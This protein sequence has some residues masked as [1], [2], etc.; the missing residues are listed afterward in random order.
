MRA[1]LP[2]RFQVAHRACEGRTE[3]VSM[4]GM[5]LLADAAPENGHALTVSVTMPNGNEAQVEAR[6]TYVAPGPFDPGYANAFAVELTRPSEELTAF[7]G[8]LV[9]A[10]TRKRGF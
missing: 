3:N 9:A 7:V 8:L 10:K 6:V 2:I 4:R 1:S 5:L